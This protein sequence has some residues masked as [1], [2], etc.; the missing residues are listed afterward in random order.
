MK[1]VTESWL[2]KLPLLKRYSAIVLGR[3]CF[4]KHSTYSEEL[5]RHELVHQEQMDRV[6]MFSFYFIYLKDYLINLVRYRNHDIAY[7]EIPFENEAYARQSVASESKSNSNR[8][9]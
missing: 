4:I 8:N 3:R 5:L 9:M 6:G 7:S 1:I 2:F